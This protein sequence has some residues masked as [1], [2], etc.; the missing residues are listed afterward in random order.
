[1][2]SLPALLALLTLKEFQHG[3]LLYRAE[4]LVLFALFALFSSIAAQTSVCP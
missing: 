2:G 4:T 3:K 1:L